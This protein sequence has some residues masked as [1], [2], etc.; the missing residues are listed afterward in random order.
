[1]QFSLDE[2]KKHVESIKEDIFEALKS[3]KVESAV[4]V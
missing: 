2:L 3:V 4:N 1:M